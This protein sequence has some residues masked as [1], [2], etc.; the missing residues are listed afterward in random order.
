MAINLT[1]GQ[2]ISL[3][4]DNG[5]KISSFCVGA[6]WGAIE[7]KGIFGTKNKAVDLDL[8]AVLFDANNIN[9]DIVYF[10]KLKAPG[11]NHSG[12]D[13]IGDT[14]GD[15]GLDNEI[16]SVNLSQLNANVKQIV[17]V[18]N[19]YNLIV[20]D[21]IPFASIRLYEGSPQRVN[22][23]FATYN[24]V[25]SQEFK[26]KMCM[27]LGKLYLRNDEWKFSAIGQA[28]NDKSLDNIIKNSIKNYL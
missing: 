21:K 13:T 8:S 12:D 25:N 19:S 5:N 9:T 15:D 23:V 17:F 4:K 2:K 22:E 6:N 24:I 10:G 3:K 16:I 26:N 27:I 28:T 20:F 7:T 14:N 1:K 18:L 11:I